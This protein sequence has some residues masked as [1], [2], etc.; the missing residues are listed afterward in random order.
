MLLKIFEGSP[1]Y[2]EEPPNVSYPKEVNRLITIPKSTRKFPH[3]SELFETLG[4]EIDGPDEQSDVKI[5]AY[6]NLCKCSENAE[7]C[8]AGGFN[9][10]LTENNIRSIT[11]CLFLRQIFVIMIY[12]ID[13]N[14]CEC[15]R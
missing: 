3:I 1:E 4:F 6:E 10:R 12:R 14:F 11:D 5:S 7:P 15:R 9:L 8:D 2:L 13:S